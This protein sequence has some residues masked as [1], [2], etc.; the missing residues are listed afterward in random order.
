[1]RDPEQGG[2]GISPILWCKWW[3]DVFSENTRMREIGVYARQPAEKGLAE[4]AFYFPH[5]TVKLPKGNEALT[6]AENR[7]RQYQDARMADAEKVVET[8]SDEIPDATVE[9]AR[10][11]FESLYEDDAV[12][13]EEEINLIDDIKEKAINSSGDE[14]SSTASIEEDVQTLDEPSKEKIR[15]TVE[16]LE[17]VRARKAI[18]TPKKD[19]PP[20][21]E[22]PIFQQYRTNRDVMAKTPTSFRKPKKDLPAYPSREYFVGPWRLVSSP[23]PSEEMLNPD[24]K[25]TSDNLILRVDGTTFGGPVLDRENMHK[26]AG[27]TWKNFQARWVGG[28][29]GSPKT[30]EQTRMRVRLVVPPEKERIL[31][32]EGEVKRLMMPSDLQETRSSFGIPLVDKANESTEMQYDNLLQCEGEMWVEDAVSGENRNKLGRFLLMKIEGNSDPGD[33][34]ITIPRG[35]RTQD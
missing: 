30:V 11:L 10:E 13:N 28:E 7:D 32:L 31:V 6:A 12:K 35:V 23:I 27:G 1:M 4:S 14:E 16:G 2:N 18:T 25:E 19:L 22:N 15:K 3:D 8:A 33:Y 17:S 24:D 21:D 9:K 34:V 26:A 5:E 29:E 20:M